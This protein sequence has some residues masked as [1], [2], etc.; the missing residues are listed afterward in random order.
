MATTKIQKEHLDTE[1]VELIDAY[2]QQP[3]VWYNGEINSVVTPVITADGDLATATDQV[4]VR[5]YAV[6]NADDDVAAAQQLLDGGPNVIDIT[7]GDAVQKLCQD[8]S[9]VAQTITTVY[10]V[11]ISSSAIPADYTGGA[12]I[13]SENE[14][15]IADVLANMARFDFS[16]GLGATY[17]R[18]ITTPVYSTNY[19]QLSVQVGVRV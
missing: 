7:C 3:T 16:S 12:Y 9:G 2:N 13:I 19:S 4:P 1:I 18:L 14:T 17:A 6:L 15:D 10:A 11:C 5:W 8:E